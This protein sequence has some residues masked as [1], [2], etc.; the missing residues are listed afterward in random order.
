MLKTL[1]HASRCHALV[2]WIL[3]LTLTA[4]VSHEPR[5]L[6][7]SISLSPDNVLS[8][9]NTGEPRAGGADL[10]ISVS[11]NESDSLSNVTVLPGVRVNSVRSGG[12]ADMAGV[13]AGDVIL[14]VDGEETNHPDTLEAIALATEEDHSFNVEIRRN[15][16][17]FTTVI[18]VT[19]SRSPRS[20]PVELYRVDPISLRAGFTT[21]RLARIDAVPVSGARIVRF[22]PESPLPDAGLAVDDV[23]VSI[24]QQA[25]ESAQGLVNMISREY[26]PGDR[27]SVE[28]VRDNTHYAQNVRLWDPGRRLSRLS[29][30]PLFVYESS[31]SPDQTRLTIGDLWLFSLFS[32]QRNQGEREYSVLGLFRSASGF[33]ELMEE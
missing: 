16:A 18:A 11:V 32:Y 21:E 30:W 13:L 5:Q 25:V 1:I 7:P 8:A 22:F 14:S 17:V 33:G 20:E 31:L 26:S 10:G 6:V 24:D 19:P 3:A 29:L 9:D 28:Y 23:I 15:T 12:P 2:L 27:V 4:C